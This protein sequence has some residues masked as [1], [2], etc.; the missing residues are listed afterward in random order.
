M[1]TTIL[2]TGA[3]GFIGKRILSLLLHQDINIVL[4]VKRQSVERLPNLRLHDKV[5]CTDNLFDESK[6]WWANACSSVDIVL[7]LAWFAEHGSYMNSKKNEECLRG[8]INMVE[9]A[10]RAGVKKI[11]G[12]GTCLEYLI[13]GQKLSVDSPLFPIS[14]YAKSKVAFY[15]FLKAQAR[16][17]QFMYAW[18]RVFFTYGDDEPI[19]KLHSHIRSEL[20][21]GRKV[22]LEFGNTTRDYLHVDLVAKKIVDVALKNFEGDFNI[23]SG[24]AVKIKELA[25]L[26]AD[27]LGIDRSYIVSKNRTHEFESIIGVPSL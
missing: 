10:K 17:Q 12:I 15:Y 11:I 6:S 25:Y 8:S 20:I 23:C 14:L 7:H 22:I 2:L 21:A 1:K 19:T 18:C 27:E 24:K 4:V 3:T 9:G 5:I 13:S 26:I 16:R